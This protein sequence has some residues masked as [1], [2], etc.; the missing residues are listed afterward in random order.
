MPVRKRKST[1]ANDGSYGG[2]VLAAFDRLGGDD[3]SPQSRRA[4]A[5]TP[6]D[7]QRAS[8]A[9]GLRTDPP[10]PPGA[11]DGDGRTLMLGG[12]PQLPGLAGI[13]RRLNAHPPQES[14]APIQTMGE[15]MAARRARRER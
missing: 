2:E 15:A 10:R 12:R 9:T 14:Q 8:I 11:M 5:H 6:T 1:E 3:V 4:K 13:V 7:S